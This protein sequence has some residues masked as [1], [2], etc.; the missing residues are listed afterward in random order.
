MY[1]DKFERIFSMLLTLLMHLF[2]PMLVLICI[3]FGIVL[4]YF[5][6]PKQFRQRC[7]QKILNI[8]QI[9]PCVRV[10]NIKKS[11]E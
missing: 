7:L 5:K 11:S 6:D 1:C 3:K 4:F 10:K 8:I 2:E 9:M